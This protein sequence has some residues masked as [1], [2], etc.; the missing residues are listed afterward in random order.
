MR[1]RPMIR[2]SVAALAL[3][4]MA[5][6]CSSPDKRTEVGTSTIVTDEP[7]LSRTHEA[8]SLLV[9]RNDPNTVYL[10]EVE[11][12]AGESRFYISSDRGASWKRSE[13]PKL[14]PYTD[15]GLGPASTKNIRTELEQDSKGTLYYLFH[16][17]DPSAGGA[18]SVLVGRSNDG[19]LTWRTT[20]VWAAPKP[21]D[22][23][24]ELNWQAHLAI[25]PANEQ[26]VYVTWRRFY[27]L[28]PGAP[29]RPVR[30][31]MAVS[32]DGGASFG[33]PVMLMD[34]ATGFEAPR[35]HVRD[36][37]LWAFYREN[38]PAAGPNVPE[39][40]LTT[41]TASVSEDQGKTWKDT[42]VMGARDASEPVSIIDRE[43]GTFYLVWHDNRSQDL[44][45]Y[46]SKSA[47]GE[48]WT[49]PRMLNDDPKGARVGQFY[50]K[51]SL[52]PGGRIDVAWYDFRNDPFPAPTVAP[53]ATAPFLGLTTNV[54]V[55]DAVYL[56]SSEDGGDT[57]SPNIRVSDVP[58]DRS[59]GTA[60]PQ[61]FVQ[62]PLAVASGE[63]WSVVAWS[64]T[65]NG[66][67]QNSTQD[68]ASN[69]VDF[70]VTEPGDFRIGHVGAAALAGLVLGAGLAMCVAV[71]SLRR[72]AA[73]ETTTGTSSGGL[74]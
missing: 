35:I 58:N 6:A 33:A 29:S 60:G 65:R 70:A 45:V 69:V 19:G 64:D 61:Y 27:Q 5:T 30:P 67:L 12:Q 73:A 16:A 68:I 49:E 71:A 42:K 24:V 11:L 50:P 15:A 22:D 8:P 20:A 23:V 40:R 66:N 54:G 36:G 25:D 57:W 47:D 41:I 3:G 14:P 2:L 51:I 37:K 18:R 55:F 21:V 43:R 48:T 4:A 62:V 31:F 26:R 46:F 9:D 44:D 52:V 39:P 53:T 74:A 7:R 10:A 72:P 1:R 56:T 63:D 34:K 32:D 38:P 28:P 59:V 13:A 17:H